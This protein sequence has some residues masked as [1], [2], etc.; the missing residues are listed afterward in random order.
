VARLS[1]ETTSDATALSLWQ[2]D[3]ATEAGRAL[4]RDGW[5]ESLDRLRALV[6]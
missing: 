4:H 5:T 3:F 2:G 1:L 6:E